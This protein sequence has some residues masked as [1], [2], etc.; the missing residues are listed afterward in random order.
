[1][2]AASPARRRSDALVA[3][4]APPPPFALGACVRLADGYAAHGSAVRF[5]HLMLH[6]HGT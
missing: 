1:M 5:S 3:L 6:S 4:S 2:A